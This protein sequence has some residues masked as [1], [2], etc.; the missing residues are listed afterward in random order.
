MSSI[1]TQLRSALQAYRSARYPGDL[2]AELLPRPGVLRSLSASLQRARWM[3]GAAGATAA[4][5]VIALTTLVS[6]VSNLPRP[7]H[8]GEAQREL[9]NWLPTRPEGLPLPRFHSPTLRLDVPPVVPSAQ[10]YR[11]LAMEYRKLQELAPDLHLKV[12]VPTLSDLPSR[13]VE[14]IERVWEDDHGQKA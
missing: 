12:T 8:S 6:R 13:S 10:R 14:W 11:D 4:A 3:I 9:A 5:A 2:A 7:V 1:R